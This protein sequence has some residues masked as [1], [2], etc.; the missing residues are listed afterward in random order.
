MQTAFVIPSGKKHVYIMLFKVCP[1]PVQLKIM[2]PSIVRCTLFEQD[3]NISE[4]VL[5]GASPQTP[6]WPY[7]IN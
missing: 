6:R 1:P 7:K 2:L 3:W 4:I 5:G